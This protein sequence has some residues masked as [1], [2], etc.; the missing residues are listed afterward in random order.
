MIVFLLGVADRRCSSSR[1]ENL[2]PKSTLDNGAIDSYHCE[3][4]QYS[5]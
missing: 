4:L 5:K 1:R 3:L 2:A